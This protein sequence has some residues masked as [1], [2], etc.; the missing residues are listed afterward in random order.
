MAY[1][2]FSQRFLPLRRRAL[3][4]LA[5]AA[6]GLLGG[7]M[8]AYAQQAPDAA[9]APAGPLK[10]VASFS[11]LGD[12]VKQIGGGDVQVDVLV[13]PDG[14]AHEYE[15]T[16]AD[17]RRLAAA[18]LVVVNGLGFEAWLPK[19]VR[20]SGF[21]GTT[22]VASE[23][24]TPRDFGGDATGGHGH[25]HGAGKPGEHAHDGNT[26]PHAWQNLANGARYARN[27]GAA[28]AAAD[29]AH[30][31]AYRQRTDAYVARIEALDAR[32]KQAFAAL[33]P[34]RRRVVTSHDAF[35]YFGDAY[36]MTFISA[37]G[38]STEAEPSAADVARIIGQ[39]RQEKVPAV[40]FENVSS[41]RLAQQIARET[42]ARVGGT[43]Y[44]DALAKPGL[45]AATY[46]GMFEWNLSQFMAALKP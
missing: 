1:A 7:S 8:A 40:F 24:V 41:P 16:P 12:M 33:P 18:Q 17:A 35:G 29:A 4:A 5:L 31:D 44:S 30:A 32:V 42:G 36:G 11:I 15:P 19:L 27:I 43:L 34:E 3:A 13:G 20:A 2:S 14:D 46:L 9:P 37:M 39:I 22:V 23:G 10:V 26:D 6:S 45:P 28:L 38:I 25:D 21:K